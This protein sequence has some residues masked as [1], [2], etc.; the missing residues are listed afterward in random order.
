MGAM[1]GGAVGSVLIVDD[2]PRIREMLSRWLSAAGHG[3]A[4]APDADAALVHLDAA[5]CDVVL[6]D[7]NMPGHDG[8]WLV[9]RLRE[10]FPAVAVVLATAESEISGSV[11][12]QPGVVGYLVKP[13]TAAGVLAAVQR[14]V[15]WRRT[16][17]SRAGTATAASPIDDWLRGGR[18]RRPSEDETNGG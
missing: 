9:A 10:R 16:E 17:A 6:C 11:T 13:F 1:T 12:L 5:A 14:A 8:L 18:P 7:V 3:I 2:D 15:E 4:E